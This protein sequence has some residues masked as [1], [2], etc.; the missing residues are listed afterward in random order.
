MDVGT[1]QAKNRISE[2]IRE[3]E[4]GKQAI[5]SSHG[6]PVAQ[7]SLPPPARRGVVLGGMKDRIRLLP[8]WDEPLDLESDLKDCPQGEPKAASFEI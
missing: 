2:S 1:Q 7:I 8:G 4:R 5:V 3:V 6:R